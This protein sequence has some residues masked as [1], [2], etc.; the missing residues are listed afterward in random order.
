MDVSNPAAVA[1]STGMAGVLRVLSGA[2]AA[3]SVRRTAQLAGI[4]HSR[5]RQVID[6]LAEHGVVSI[7]QQGPSLLCRLNWEHLATRPLVELVR[8]RSRMLGVLKEELESWADRPEHG[9]LFGSA[10]RGDGDTSSDLDV[11]VVRPDTALDDDAAWRDRLAATGE[12]LHA[13]TGNEVAWFDVS[14][15]DLRRALREGE[16]VVDEWRRDAVHLVGTDLRQLLRSL[17]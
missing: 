13:A 5:G 1:L 4:S 14:R 9:S 15:D 6:R 2:E 16:P 7:E 3:F 8:L 17:T 12:R 11:L 10:A